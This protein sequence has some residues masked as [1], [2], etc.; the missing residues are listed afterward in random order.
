[1]AKRPGGEMTGY[2]KVKHDINGRQQTAKI[3]SDFEFFSSN[4]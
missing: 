4:P 2:Q 1:M 3:T